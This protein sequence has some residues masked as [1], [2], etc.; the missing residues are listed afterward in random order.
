MQKITLIITCLLL[1]SCAGYRPEPLTK[2][3]IAGEAAWLTLHT[4]DWG[5]TLTIAD[6][7]DKHSERN[8]ILGEHPSRGSVNLYMG[9]WW[10]A[11]PIITYLLPSDWRKYWIGGSL[12]GTGYCVFHNNSV[13]IGVGF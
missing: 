10:I 1:V 5:Q 3:Q 4:I 12:I 2:W 13:G 9:A 6:N 11:H 8:P 7:P